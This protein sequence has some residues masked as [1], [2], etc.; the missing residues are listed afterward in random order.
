MNEG[1]ETIGAATESPEMVRFL[2]VEQKELEVFPDSKVKKAFET[3][4]K[5]LSLKKLSEV[6]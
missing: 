3:I 5:I 1:F 4:S 6:K 2:S